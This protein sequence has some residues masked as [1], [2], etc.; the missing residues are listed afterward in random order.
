MIRKRHLGTL[1]V[2]RTLCRKIQCG[3]VTQS[4]AGYDLLLACSRA[5]YVGVRTAFDPICQELA[6]GGPLV[7]LQQGTAAAAS[8]PLP[9]DIQFYDPAPD[10][11]PQRWF[12]LPSGASIPE[13]LPLTSTAAAAQPAALD[14]IPPGND[15]PAMTEDTSTTPA[16]E[17]TPVTETPD[18]FNRADY[19]KLIGST[20]LIFGD[21][22]QTQAWLDRV[23]GDPLKSLVD[24]GVTLGPL[25]LPWLLWL[26]IAAAGA[27]SIRKNR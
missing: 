4:Q 19:A 9:D 10:G 18:A 13:A 27:Y 5:G 16:P 20:D 22:E 1:G 8:D 23:I 21:R 3:L 7:V 17:T 24:R 6:G 26:A 11:T 15:S 14:W 12:T 25:G 2:D